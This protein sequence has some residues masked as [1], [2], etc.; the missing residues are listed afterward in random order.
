MNSPMRQIHTNVE[1][2]LVITKEE[3]REGWTRSL[4]L[5]DANCC[6]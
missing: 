2:R 3:G 1:D 4:E 5:V 6:V